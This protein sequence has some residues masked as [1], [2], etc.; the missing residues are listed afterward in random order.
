VSRP[1]PK[2]ILKSSGQRGVVSTGEINEKDERRTQVQVNV[3]PS[4]MR[5][6]QR[7]S[8]T[9]T[10]VARRRAA[11]DADDDRIRRQIEQDL[12]LID[13]PTTYI[14][15]SYTNVCGRSVDESQVL[16]SLLAHMEKAAD[17]D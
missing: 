4:S 7:R 17:A 5:S 6:V 8:T 1:E 12:R 14:N 10:Q 2:S 11:K 9:T 3:R 15:L 16:L 13:W